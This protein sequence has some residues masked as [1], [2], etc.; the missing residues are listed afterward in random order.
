VVESAGLDWQILTFDELGAA[1]LYAILRLRQ[2]V[3]VVEQQSIYQDLD[4]LDQRA[5]HMIGCADGEIAAY[6]RC[7]APGLSYPES[8]MGRIIVSPAMRGRDLGRDLVQRGIDYN[9]AQWP[10]IAIRINAQ[11]YLQDFYA[12]MGFVA[13]GEEYMEDG[14]PHRQMRYAAP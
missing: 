6:L 5:M 7:L 13:E 4:N 3:F 2:A 1:G 8:S 12:S 9:L 14:I 10:A 11:S